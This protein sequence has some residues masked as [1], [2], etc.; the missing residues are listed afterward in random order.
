MLLEDFHDALH[1]VHGYMD[2]VQYYESSEVTSAYHTA[3]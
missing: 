2:S 3:A 1:H